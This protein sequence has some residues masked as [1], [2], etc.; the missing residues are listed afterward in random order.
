MRTVRDRLEYD[1]KYKRFVQGLIPEEDFRRY[2]LFSLSK[3]D[4]ANIIVSGAKSLRRVVAIGESLEP[5]K[6]LDSTYE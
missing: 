1:R 2:L 3:K 4:L 5:S 6:K